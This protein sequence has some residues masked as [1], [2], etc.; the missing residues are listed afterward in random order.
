M[1]QEDEKKY[2]LNILIYEYL[3]KNHFDKTASAFKDELDITDF[4]PSDHAPSL[5]T[6]YNAFIETAEVRSGQKFIPESLNRIEGIML[7]LENEKQRYSRM[8]GSSQA[9]GP[10]GMRA[11]FDS[12]PQQVPNL[13]K[14][15]LHHLNG[16][17]QDCTIGHSAQN[18]RGTMQ[19]NIQVRNH[20]PPVVQPIL[21]EIKRIDLG[22]PTITM[23]CFCPLNNI[24]IAHSSDS[25]IHF[26]NLATNEIEYD[27]STQRRT[28]RMIKSR[29]VSGVIY[30]AYSCDGYCIKLCKYEHMKKDDINAFELETSIKGFCLNEECLYVLDS[31]GVKAFAFSGIFMNA[32]SCPDA[33]SIEC[34]GNNLVVAE[35][36]KISEY[37]ARLSTETGVVARGAYLSLR[38][39]RNVAFI[40]SS[41]SIQAIDSRMGS[42]VASVKCMLPYKD[43]SILS[44]TI[45]VCT[46]A[47][48]F[49]ASDVIP[50]KNPIEIAQFNC[51]NHGGLLVVSSD[52]IVILFSKIQAYE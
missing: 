29:E 19:G 17:H 28:M 9:K 36:S 21:S 49:Y 6:W 13:D 42:V 39:K 34:F 38:V 43:L 10:S 2:S 25:T 26:Y 51:L 35:E 45:A 20:M 16:R 15:D 11:P 3:L 5:S 23:S 41:D 32:L 40:I 12:R 24:L 30:F 44:N 33:V 47:E 48:L 50:L 18:T 52:G 27:F 14:C 8:K 4:K 46:S 22:L 31:D 37:D 7:K 1:T